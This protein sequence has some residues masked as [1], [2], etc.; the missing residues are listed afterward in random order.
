MLKSIFISAYGT[1][2][3]VLSGWVV[4]AL[5]SGAPALPWFGALLAIA[6]LPVLLGVFMVARPAARTSANLPVLA[7]LIGTG[8]ALAIAGYGSGGVT[9][10]TV[11]VTGVVGYLAYVVWYSRFGRVRAAT[12]DVGQPLPDFELQ[13]HDGN[14]FNSK[15]LRGAPAV[16]MFYRGNWCPL[17]VAQVRE[18]AAAYRE[19][20]RRG[21]RVLLVSP[22]PAGHSASLSRKFDAP[23]EFLV[24]P[25][26]ATARQLGIADRYGT[27]AGMQALGYATETVMPTVL[28]V[29]ADGLI[30]LSDQ[31]DNY[32]VRPEPETFLAALDAAKN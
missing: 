27:P 11:A 20:E 13:T 18:M 30:L 32:R 10:I 15:S 3:A 19:L 14:A 29:D 22:Q 2:A 31:T 5:V 1:A 6:P 26:N 24:D 21:A 12:I 8:L 7:A 4:Y 17:C 16:V 23:M 25:D 9:P 28:V